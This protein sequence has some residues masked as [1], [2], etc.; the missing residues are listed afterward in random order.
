VAHYNVLIA[1]FSQK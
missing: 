1:L